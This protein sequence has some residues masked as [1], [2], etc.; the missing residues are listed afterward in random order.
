MVR[1]NILEEGSEGIGNLL[2]SGGIKAVR[3][4]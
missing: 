1:E 4:L 3:V 2:R